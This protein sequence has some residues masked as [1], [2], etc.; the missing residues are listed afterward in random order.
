MAALLQKLQEVSVHSVTTWQVCSLSE[1]W[2]G[3]LELNWQNNGKEMYVTAGLIWKGLDD[4]EFGIGVPKNITRGSTK[5]GAILMA[6]YEFLI[7][8]N[9][10]W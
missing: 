1:T 4:F 10:G 3:T 2:R 6:T 8:K 9:K 5:W 7:I